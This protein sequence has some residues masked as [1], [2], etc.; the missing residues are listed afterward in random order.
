MF[1]KE[2]INITRIIYIIN[3]VVPILL[4]NYYNNVVCI[5][6]LKLIT[7]DKPE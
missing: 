5:N 7:N 3:I 2:I 4:Y 1:N 6:Y